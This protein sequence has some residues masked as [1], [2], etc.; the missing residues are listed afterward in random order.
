MRFMGVDCPEPVVPR[1]AT[2]CPGAAVKDTPARMSRSLPGY[3][4]ETS[5][6]STRQEMGG[7]MEASGASFTSRGA[8]RTSKTLWAEAPAR[9]IDRKE[10]RVGKECRSR[11]SPYH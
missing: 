2:V 6:K 5:S 11:W 8:S 7:R 3:R 9:E 1:T 10:R 4:K